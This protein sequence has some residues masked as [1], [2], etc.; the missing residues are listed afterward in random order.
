MA[1][2][3]AQEMRDIAGRVAAKHKL[4]ESELEARGADKPGL[5]SDFDEASLRVR[6]EYYKQRLDDPDLEG[7][8]VDDDEAMLVKWPAED[9]TVL[10]QLH[11]RLHT[12]ASL[13]ASATEATSVLLTNRNLPVS[14]LHIPPNAA[15]G[16]Y[17]SCIQS[18]LTNLQKLIMIQCCFNVP[19][20]SPEN[21]SN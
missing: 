17:E 3:V 18:I 7:P 13:A 2:L 12:I 15:S 8:G 5:R 16:R 20:W 14:V 11:T 10:E 4:L 19:L 6:E 1:G 21:M 9:W